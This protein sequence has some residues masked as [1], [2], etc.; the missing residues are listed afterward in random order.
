MEPRAFPPPPSFTS[1]NLSEIWFCQDI[2]L[3]SSYKNVILFSSR[4]Q[5]LNWFK[6]KAKVHE[7]GSLNGQPYVYDKSTQVRLNG[8]LRVSNHIGNLQNV[9]YLFFHNPN[10]DSPNEE[11]QVWYFCFIDKVEYINPNTTEVD[12]TIDVFNTWLGSWKILPSY[13]ERETPDNDGIFGHTQPEGLE[14]GSYTVVENDFLDLDGPSFNGK[15]TGINLETGFYSYFMCSEAQPTGTSVSSKYWFP[16]RTDTFEPN[17]ANG[18]RSYFETE[19]Y[20]IIA[21]II[22]PKWLVNQK[23]ARANVQKTYDFNT[24]KLD[25]N[26]NPCN[27]KLFSYPYTFLEITNNLGE[28][29]ILRWEDFDTYSSPGVRECTF[30]LCSSFGMVPEI[31]LMPHNYLGNGNVK[32]GN[33]N[34]QYNQ[35]PQIPWSSDAYNQWYNSNISQFKASQARAEAHRYTTG[36]ASVAGQAATGNLGGAISTAVGNVVDS[37]H[38]GYVLDNL[39]EDL[40]RTPDAV[41]NFTG[42]SMYNYMQNRMGFTFKVKTIKKE[43]ARKVD[44]YLTRFGYRVGY[45]KDIDLNTVP[46][47]YKYVRT[48][49]ANVVCYRSASQRAG[50]PTPA[51]L[52]IKSAF[53]AGITFWKNPDGVGNYGVYLPGPYGKPSTSPINFDNSEMEG[54][55]DT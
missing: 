22:A 41:T 36:V 51:L 31:V 46:R 10:F 45:L 16:F 1:P 53:D 19:G 3:D 13:V 54:S 21:G 44:A 27:K 42:A 55:N 20:K 37:Y 18:I 17:D 50:F 30:D 25:F 12:Y 8:K 11:R 39:R 48:S 34:L 32:T 7:G 5:Q 26:Y 33:F 52:T 47:G 15:I 43:Y 23:G 24:F 4:T 35:F 2:P 6:S 49:C 9:N 29:Q 38:D 28:T 40:Q 14:C